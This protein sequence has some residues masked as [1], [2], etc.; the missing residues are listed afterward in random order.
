MLEKSDLNPFLDVTSQDKVCGV[1][2]TGN[3]EIVRT[4]G[5]AASDFSQASVFMV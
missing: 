5:L 2:S 4:D 1:S 3:K